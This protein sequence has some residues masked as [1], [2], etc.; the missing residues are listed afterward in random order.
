MAESSEIPCPA[1]PPEKKFSIS[2]RKALIGGLVATAAALFPQKASAPTMINNLQE[3]VRVRGE[4]EIF[5]DRGVRVFGEV[6]P[7][8]PIAWS[9]SLGSKGRFNVEQMVLANQKAIETKQPTIAVVQRVSVPQETNNPSIPAK[10]KAIVKELPA[11]VVPENELGQRG[12]ENVNGEETE[13]YF[14][15]DIFEK[16]NLLESYQIGSD[17]KLVIILTDTP[18]HNRDVFNNPRYD[19]VR[20]LINDIY[21]DPNDEKKQAKDL[22]KDKIR[23]LQQQLS[24]EREGIV[25]YQIEIKIKMWETLSDGEITLLGL[26]GGTGYYHARKD[27]NPA[28]ILMPVGD[29]PKSLE[30]LTITANPY[31]NNFFEQVT[32]LD[33]DQEVPG[34]PRRKRLSSQDSFPVPEEFKRT[35]STGGKREA[36]IEPEDKTKGFILRHELAHDWRVLNLTDAPEK[37]WDEYETDLTTLDS[38]VK[39]TSRRQQGDGRG[40][41]IVLRQ[42]KTGLIILT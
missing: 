28:V 42:K 14:T 4:R 36:A 13:L 29:R 5:Y 32:S 19:K 20:H 10:E 11:D 23:L 3:S 16:G 27:G 6:T 8:I 22:R 15:R 24:R 9:D 39:A 7:K 25:K 38:I 34:I 1:P 26:T 37:I 21:P 17:K 12:I 41:S 2:R 40:D 33:L 18:T 30:F 31:E 35:K